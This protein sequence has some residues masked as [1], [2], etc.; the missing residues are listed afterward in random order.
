MTAQRKQSKG[1]CKVCELN[2]RVESFFRYVSNSS[3]GATFPRVRY[4]KTP[5]ASSIDLSKCLKQGECPHTI[6]IK[7]LSRH[8]GV[9]R[10]CLSVNLGRSVLKGERRTKRGMNQAVETRQT[11]ELGR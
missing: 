4:T 5:R 1:R 10:G 6:P 9:P 8:L 7:Q 11:V 3:R 2:L